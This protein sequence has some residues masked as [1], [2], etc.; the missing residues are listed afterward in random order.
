MK[1]L[2]LIASQQDK[3]FAQLK[4]IW[5]FVFVLCWNKESA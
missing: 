4:F 2:Y 3:I 5:S 1:Y